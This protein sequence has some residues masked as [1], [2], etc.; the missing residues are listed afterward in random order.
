MLL[1]EFPDLTWIRKQARSNFEERKDARGK[2]LPNSGW[3]SVILNTRAQQG[4]RDGILGPFSIF[5]NLSGESVVRTDRHAHK[6]NDGYYY[7]SNHGQEYDLH[8][9]E[10]RPIETFN[11]HFGEQ[12][13]QEVLATKDQKHTDLLD[14]GISQTKISYELCPK[15]HHKFHGF[16]T[17]IAPLI[18]AAKEIKI[19]DWSADREYELL[20]E[21]LNVV[22][23]Q[24]DAFLARGQTI[25]S[26]KKSTQ[27]ELLRRVAV[28]V[29]CLHDHAPREM[30]LNELSQASG[31]SK[32]HLLRVF[33]QV[34]GCTPMQYIAQLRLDR[35]TN[36]LQR[37]DLSPTEIS[38]QLGFSELPAFT[39]F[40]KRHAGLSPKAY[41][42]RS[43][44]SNLG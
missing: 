16:N 13:Y 40:M 25:S 41:K 22:L 11:I 34:M 5:L 4:E 9:P 42:A 2:K 23:N 28:A 27:S 19:A 18:A 15:L 44:I 36:L 8:I 32:F 30:A 14:L 24:N 10:G 43:K 3:P 35:A 7:V 21:L 37:T 26:A 6:V 39:R 38:N 33:K 17:V 29:D 20:S 1:N 31:L 12:L